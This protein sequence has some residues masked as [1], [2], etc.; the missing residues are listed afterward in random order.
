MGAY[1]Q[2]ICVLGAGL[3]MLVAGSKSGH[4]HVIAADSGRALQSMM[5]G[6]PSPPRST[7]VLSSL[8]S[9]SGG[10]LC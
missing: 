2:G 6:Q 5:L 8:D 9:L 7:G 1:T 4:V 3:P 10:T